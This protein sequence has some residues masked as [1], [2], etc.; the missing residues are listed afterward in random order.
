MYIYLIQSKETGQF[1]IG[2]SK[3]VKK[4]IKQLQTGNSGELVLVDSFFTKYANKLE[5]YLHNIFSYEKTMGE[6]FSLSFSDISKIRYECE[7]MEK[8]YIFLEKNKES[9]V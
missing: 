8:N 6:W 7:K 1:K 9:I 3:N 2:K 5:K 4:R